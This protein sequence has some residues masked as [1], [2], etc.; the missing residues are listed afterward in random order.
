MGQAQ[1]VSQRYTEAANSHNIEAIE[2][3]FSDAAVLSEPAGEFKGREAIVEYWREMFEAF[4][5]LEARDELTAEAGDAAINEWVFA[6]TN[7]GPMKTPEGTI[8]PTGKR[9][10]LRGCDVVTV[11]DGRIE[12]HRV[13]YDQLAMMTQL[14]LVSEGAATG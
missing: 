10:R 5:D 1:D 7:S 8:P 9:V 4:P 6:G 13:Y 2:A 12:S 11:R 14:G 3:L